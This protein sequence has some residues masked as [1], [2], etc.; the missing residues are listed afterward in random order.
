MT[1]EIRATEILNVIHT[2]GLKSSTLREDTR[3]ENLTLDHEGSTDNDE[4]IARL[5][6]EIANEKALLSRLSSDD[7]LF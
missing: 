7:D 1:E 4:S 5:E 6:A 2:M 3:M